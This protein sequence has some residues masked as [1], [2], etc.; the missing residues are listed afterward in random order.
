MELLSLDWLKL[1]L[2][3]INTNG[4]SL[5]SNLV[6]FLSKFLY[7]YN[8]LPFV[9]LIDDKILAQSKLN[10]T[11]NC[12]KGNLDNAAAGPIRPFPNSEKLKVE[13]ENGKL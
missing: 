8:K 1:P 12:I 13:I 7:G 10:K 3:N 6:S 11:I 4:Y 5:K 9:G 2:I